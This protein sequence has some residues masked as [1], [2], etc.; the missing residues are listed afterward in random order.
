[1]Q[2][3]WTKTI[4]ILLV[5]GMLMAVQAIPLGPVLAQGAGPNLLT[6]GDFEAPPV[7]PMQDGIGEIQVAP[8]WRAWYLDSPPSYVERPRW[9]YN[10]DES[11]KDSGCYWMRPE[12]RDNVAASFANRVHGGIRS[13]KYFSFGRMHQAGLMQRVTGVTPGAI[14]RFSIYIQ[15]WMC[16]DIDKCGINGIISDAPSDMHLRVGIDPYGG[17]DP[18]SPNIIWAP[19]QEAFDRWVEFSVQATAQANAV[20]VFTHSRPDWDWARM[21]NDVYLDDASLVQIGGPG[22][23]VAP[24]TTPPQATAE[25]AQPTPIATSTTIATSTPAVTR[26]PRPDGAVVH[27]VQ[28]GDTLSGIS[29]QYDVLL[30]ELYRLNNLNNQSI[31]KVG[32]EIVVQV[33]AT[34]APPTATSAPTSLPATATLPP[35]TATPALGSLCLSAFEDVNGNNL[36]DGSELYLAAV[37]FLVLS[38]QD[39]SQAARYQT[40]DSPQPH[41]LTTLP[42]NAYTVKIKAPPGY[43]AVPDQAGVGLTLGKPVNLSVA[44]RKDSPLTPASGATELVQPAATPGTQQ[45]SQ[46]T[47]LPAALIGGAVLL[48]GLAGIGVIVLRRRN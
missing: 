19:E 31:L 7:W 22:V 17:T 28:S 24:P 16:F 33:V 45:T 35:P 47:I 8:G 9:C 27:V 29:F 1:M 4:I 11:P 34:P 18:F 25:S 30:E 14:L 12:F 26:T 3:N 41:C 5:V 13:Q 37:N 38:G 2:S 36:M 23:I 43:I 20:T 6:D 39:G 46:G 40:D 15:A 48:L 42:P 21:D 10:D 44:I 32:Q